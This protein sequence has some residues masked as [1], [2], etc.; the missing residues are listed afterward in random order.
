MERFVWT[1]G[2]VGVV[3]KE[4]TAEPILGVDRCV[5]TMLVVPVVRSATT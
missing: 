1:S 3:A 4:A 2:N 5:V